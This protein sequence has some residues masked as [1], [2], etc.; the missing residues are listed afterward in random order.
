MTKGFLLYEEMRK[1]LFIYEEA[2]SL[3]DYATE[4]LCIS[5][6]ARKIFFSFFISVPLLASD[7]NT[8][9]KNLRFYC[10]EDPDLDPVG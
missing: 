2:V 10:V 8:V 9:T 4:P 5:L 7:L 6:Y 3:Y 1:F